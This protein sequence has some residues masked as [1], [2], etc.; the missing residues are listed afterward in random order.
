MYKRQLQLTLGITLISILFYTP[1]VVGLPIFALVLWWVKVPF[2]FGLA[3]SLTFIF[4]ISIG[5][6]IGM[7]GAHRSGKE[8]LIKSALS[9][10]LYWLLLFAPAMRAIS[11]LKGKRFLWHKTR[12]GV[13]RPTELNT[14]SKASENNVSLRRSTD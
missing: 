4:S 12:H 3:Y 1:V 10:P 9:M 6:L 14:L 13:S 8:K 5:C 7:V 2:D 11:E